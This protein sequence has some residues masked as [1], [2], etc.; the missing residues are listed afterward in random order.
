MALKTSSRT[1]FIKYLLINLHPAGLSRLALVLS[2]WE[3]KCFSSH[4]LVFFTLASS[5]TWQMTERLFIDDH[6]KPISSL[7]IFVTYT[8]ILS[9]LENLA[10]P[11]QK[12]PVFSICFCFEIS[13]LKANSGFWSLCHWI[14]LLV[15]SPN[16]FIQTWSSIHY[17]SWH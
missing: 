10:Y 13:H 15:K 5:M 2:V 7:A 6:D 9:K 17:I 1:E 4:L 11:F 8:V 14:F 12:C 3:C 16:R